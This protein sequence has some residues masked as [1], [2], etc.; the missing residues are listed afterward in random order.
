MNGKRVA[1]AIWCLAIIFLF[2][3]ASLAEKEEPK[4]K[5]GQKVGNPRFQKPLS[6]EDARYLGMES[7][8]EFNLKDV[9]APYVLVAEMATTCPYSAEQAPIIN[10][11]YNMVMQDPSLKEKVKFIGVGSRQGEILMRMWK[12]ALKVPY[13]MIPDPG[14]DFAKALKFVGYP[15]TL[16]LN[17]NGKILWVDVGT[18]ENAE[19]VLKEIKA[20]IK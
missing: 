10:S 20:V 16:L 15:V 1:M 9:K 12:A 11:L 19:K 18:P 7:V 6:I 4:P 8:A 2:S 17:K 14:G 5:V 3:A 13:P